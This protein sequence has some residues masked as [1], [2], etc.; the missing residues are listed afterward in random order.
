MPN[1]PKVTFPAPKGI[2]C[3]MMPIHIFDEECLPEFCR[4]YYSMVRQC[5]VLPYVK[6]VGGP[7]GRD[8][9]MRVAYLTIH[10]SLVPVGE[11]QRRPGVHIERPGCGGKGALCRKAEDPNGYFDLAW[12]LGMWHSEED[13]PVDGIYMASNVADS[14]AIWPA[15][16]ERPDEVTDR[17]G[18]LD[19]MLVSRLGPGVPIGA[20]ELVWFT[21]RT[22]HQALPLQAPALDPGATHVYRQF[23]RL[24]AGPI[25]VWHSKHN[26][27]SPLGVLPDA[28]ISAEDKFFEL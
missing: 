5:P 17:H 20:N 18:S 12:G 19:S 1:K 16:I 25:S 28:P 6:M 8:Y 24:V 21:D 4:Q 26:T 3:N 13:R 22:P 14:T 11:T 27:P 15:L 23:F 9:M 2:C 7:S 10:E